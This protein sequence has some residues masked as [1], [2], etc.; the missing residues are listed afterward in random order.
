LNEEW[1]KQAE[2][3]EPPEKK[4]KSTRTTGTKK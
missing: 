2:A 1:Q 4:S 3:S